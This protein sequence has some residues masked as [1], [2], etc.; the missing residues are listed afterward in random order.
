MKKSHVFL[1]LAFAWIFSPQETFA[2][3]KGEPMLQV[4]LGIASYTFRNQWKNG[5]P[6][7]LDII[8]QMGFTEFEGG[9]PQGV[10]PEDFK[11]MLSDRGIS[12]PST[13]TGFEALESDPQAVADKAKALGTRYVM[14]AWVPHKRGE[15]N[16]ADADRAIKAF[17]E[18]G[19]VL[20]ENGIT[21]KYHVHGYEFQP[22]GNGTLF[23][24]LVKNTDPKYVSLQMDIMWTHFGGG[25]PAALLKKYKKRWVSLHL[26]D[27]K[28]GAPKDMT[29][30]TGPE[31]DVPLGQGELNFP[32]ILRQANKIGIKHMFI[33][34]ESDLELEA[35]PKS[36]AYLKSLK[37]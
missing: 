33:E 22:Y 25:D 6:Q 37:Y 11:K 7:T 31:N 24:Y 17:N 3:K 15:F 2:Q 10:S 9:A 27:F 16:K 5:V 23:D 12:I 1:L 13:G 34:D 29:G 20:K 32:A 18:G 28:K 35:L 19:K 21:F 14:C 36:I 4:P 8:Q 26:K 30:L